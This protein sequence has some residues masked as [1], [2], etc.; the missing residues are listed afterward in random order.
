[1]FCAKHTDPYC[2]VDAH[3]YGYAIV[4]FS[5]NETWYSVL[6]SERAQGSLDKLWSAFDDM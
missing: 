4:H 3:N 1:M 2:T 5:S 6:K